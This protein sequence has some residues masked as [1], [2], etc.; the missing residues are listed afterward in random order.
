MTEE[1][2][3]VVNWKGSGRGPR[4]VDL[5]WVLWGCWNEQDAL[6]VI[7]AY[8]RH[9]ELTDEELDRLDAVMSIRPLYLTCF[10][11]RRNILT[12]WTEDVMGFSDPGHINEVADV[13]RGAFAR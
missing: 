11:Y 2:P 12:G 5:G 6:P 4:V 10:G 8:R 1:G 7:D 9:V 13:V 3:V